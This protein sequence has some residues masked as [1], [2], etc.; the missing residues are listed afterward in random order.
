M[1]STIVKAADAAQ[2]LSFVPRLLGYHPTRSLVVIPFHGSRS[3]GAMRV[4][5]PDTATAAVDSIASTVI[6][7]VCR[8]PH[9]DGLATVAYTGSSF[10]GHAGMPHRDLVEALARRADACGLRLVDALCVTADA[11]GSYLDPSCPGSGRALA[12]LDAVPAELAEL[13]APSG[14]QGSGAELPAIDDAEREDVARAL[15]AVNRAVTVLCG[16]DV[17]SSAE[18]DEVS[19]ESMTDEG[20]V[21]PRALATACLLDDLPDLFEDALAWDAAALDPYRAA[22]LVWCLSRP[23]LRDVA[24]VQWSGNLAQGDEAF[25]AQLRWEDGEEYPEHLAMRM[26]GEGDRPDPERLERALQLVRHAAAVAPRSARPGPLSMCAWLSW[27]LGRSTHAEAYA[28]RACDIEPEH[29]LSE[30][31]LSFV[32]AGHLPEFVWSR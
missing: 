13:P 9:A 23:S 17:A 29:G 6:G 18:A 31:V 3:L 19:D 10:G 25:D 30:I 12:D 28:Q 16:T 4:D 11:W 15:G 7:M 26:W 32:R 14:D 5:L 24:L 8:L 20:R 1:T 27:A 21:D 22:A 2:F